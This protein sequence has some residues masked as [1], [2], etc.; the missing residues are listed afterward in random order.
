MFTDQ[1]NKNHLSGTGG[2][3][4]AGS[5]YI[6]PHQFDFAGCYV[7]GLHPIPLPCL[8]SMAAHLLNAFLPPE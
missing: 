1:R 8:L 4:T 6:M 7:G 2:F 5:G 3:F